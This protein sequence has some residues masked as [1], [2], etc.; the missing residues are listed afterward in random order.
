VIKS[1]DKTKEAMK[2]LEYDILDRFQLSKSKLCYTV[3]TKHNV[4]GTN[5]IIGRSEC[6]LSDYYVGDWVDSLTFIECDNDERHAVACSYAYSL[7]KKSDELIINKLNKTSNIVQD[8][9]VGMTKEKV[10]KA[11]K[12]LNDNDI[13]DD[14]QRFAI[15][16]IRQYNE[17]AKL[18]EFINAE[19]VKEDLPV[20]TD[21][22]RWLGI[23]WILYNSLPEE[24]GNRTCFVYHKSAVGHAS[25]DRV[26]IDTHYH[27]ERDSNFVSAHIDQGAVL[28]D[29]KAIVKIIC[30]D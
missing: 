5:T 29:D 14:G 17:L 4:K 23:N 13:P 6:I 22:K 20:G 18:E 19:T 10:L 12:R 25:G 27:A 21:A 7:G 8:N 28:I 3:T 16:G 9:N 24:A 1:N 26:K 11:I 2:Q 30:K 15:V